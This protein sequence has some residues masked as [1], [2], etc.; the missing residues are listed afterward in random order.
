LSD[1]GAQ[2]DKNLLLVFVQREGY[3]GLAVLARGLNERQ[4]DC[5]TSV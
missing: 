4:K 1:K 5:E 2:N 3:C